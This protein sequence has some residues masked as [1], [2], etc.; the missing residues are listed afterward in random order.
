M[1]NT[2]NGT[3]CTTVYRKPSDRRSFLQYKSVHPNTLKDS[4]A[5][6]EALR[7]KQICSETPEV[8]KHLK[9]VKDPFIKRGYHSKI[10]DHHFEKDVSVDR[11][12]LLQKRRSHLPKEMYPQQNNHSLPI[13]EI[14]I[15]TN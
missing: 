14:P 1:Y 3:L 6:S 4:I 11:K 10:L 13:E 9:D 2:E 12:I 7:L 15:C 5:Y 8:I